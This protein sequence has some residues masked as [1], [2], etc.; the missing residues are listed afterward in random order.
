MAR[1][2]SQLRILVAVT[3]FWVAWA[4]WAVFGPDSS[5]ALVVVDELGRPVAGARVIVGGSEVAHTDLSG[6][7][8]LPWPDG[9]I[10]RVEANGYFGQPATAPTVDSATTVRLIP[11]TLRGVVTDPDGRPVR[12][13]YVE[14]G[15]GSATSSADGSFEVRLADAG[16][17]RVWRP[18]WMPGDFL[19]DGGLGERTV[20]IEP[21]IVKAVHVTGQVAGDPTA[22][23]AMLHLKD[24]TELNGIMLD[25]KDEYGLIHYDTAVELAKRAGA[26]HPDYD[27]AGIV[28]DA[29][30]RDLYLIGRITTFQDPLAARAIPDMAAYDTATGKPYHKGGQWFLDPTDPQARGYALSLAVEA[31]QFG[32]DEIQF[33]YVRYPD[34]LPDSV[35][36]DGGKDADTRVGAIESFLLEARDVLHPLGCAVGGD[37]FGFITTARDDGGIGQQW[38]VVADALDVV[39]PMLY[40]SHYA[41]DWYGYARPVDHPGEMVQRALQ[42]GIKRLDTGTVIR[43]WLQDFGYTDE[44]VRAETHSAEGFG[45]G[46]ML[47]NAHSNVSVGALDGP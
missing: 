13:V 27:L 17:V 38:E 11:Q 1:R 31:C 6:T 4:A 39:S 30:D 36:F 35:V 41:A 15:Q 42:D 22:W 34:G 40:P 33:D 18:A 21:R 44:Q 5:A 43:P 26:I 24:T 2:S 37:I 28:R 23:Q 14:S 9:R 25:L 7:A 8:D 16:S 32:F 29:R 20:V 10:V 47:W 19:W 45:L 12:G 3:A 46:W